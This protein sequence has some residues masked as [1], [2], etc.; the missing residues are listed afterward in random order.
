MASN[1]LKYYDNNGHHRSGGGGSGNKRKLSGSESP[2]SWLSSISSTTGG[3]TPHPRSKSNHVKYSHY[4]KP[5]YY[6]KYNFC[7]ANET[8]HDIIGNEY[9]AQYANFYQY[10]YS[11]VYQNYAEHGKNSTL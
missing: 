9:E 7:P 4:N 10:S 8:V 1:D 5:H 6:P 11:S 2:S 3:Y